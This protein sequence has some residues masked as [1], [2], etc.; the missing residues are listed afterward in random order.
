MKLMKHYENF[1]LNCFVGNADSEFVV[2]I[3]KSV[4]QEK[5]RWSLPRCKW[6]LFIIF[7]VA[8]PKPATWSL[9][10]VTLLSL[11]LY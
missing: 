8:F 9:K 4:S 7:K 11:Q 10:P 1:I 5:N 3:F 2:R 6:K